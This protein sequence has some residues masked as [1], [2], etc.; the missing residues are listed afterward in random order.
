MERPTCPCQGHTYSTHCWE[1]THQWYLE[2]SETGTMW[3]QCRCG[4]HLGTRIVCYGRRYYPYLQSHGDRRKRKNSR[5]KEETLEPELR[6]SRAW[7]TGRRTG[8][9]LE[10]RIGSG[11]AYN[12]NNNNR[13]NLFHNLPQTDLSF[14]IISGTY[15][16]VYLLVLMKSSFV[17]I[18]KQIV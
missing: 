3:K 13:L 4:P 10:E 18:W 17:F 9:H 12:N 6:P 16:R 8:W 5:G 7:G 1:A 11:G 14:G 15:I 2:V